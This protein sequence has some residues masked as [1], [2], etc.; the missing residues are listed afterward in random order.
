M[1]NKFVVI[2]SGGTNDSK[3]KHAAFELDENKG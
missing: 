2:V 1:V 3:A